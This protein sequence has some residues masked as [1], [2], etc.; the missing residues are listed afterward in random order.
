MAELS[1]PLYKMD[2]HVH[3]TASACYEDHMYPEANLNTTPEDIV[4]AAIKAGLEAIVI[5]DHNTA[6]GIDPIRQAARGRGLAIFPGAEVTARGGHV[7]A[8]FDPDTEAESIQDL[9]LSLGFKDSQLGDGYYATAKWMD[10]VF[11]VISG[12]GGMAIA[13]HVD[14]QP[15]GFTASSE[16][17]ADKIRIHSHPCLAALEITD[18]R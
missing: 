12:A 6:S 7:L 9:I 15:K 4:A 18:P 17:L 3:T 16:A 1:L 14:R 11:E 5:T 2:F 13:A 8:I 10:E